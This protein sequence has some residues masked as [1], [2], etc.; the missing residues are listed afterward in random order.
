MACLLL[1]A[2]DSKRAR[3]SA[4]PHGNR[5]GEFEMERSLW[6]EQSEKMQFEITGSRKLVSSGWKLTPY[7]FNIGDVNGGRVS[8]KLK[9]CRRE[10]ILK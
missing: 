6:A 9:C 7:C 2:G 5:V 8:N 3:C 1:N 4:H 10:N